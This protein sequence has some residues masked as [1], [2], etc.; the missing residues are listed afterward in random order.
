[1]AELTLECL[2]GFVDCVDGRIM[3]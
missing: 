1:M 2:H 3:R